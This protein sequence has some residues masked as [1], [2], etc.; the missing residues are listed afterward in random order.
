M[1][2]YLVSSFN[3]LRRKRIGR[4]EKRAFFL[5]LFSCLRRIIIV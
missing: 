3:K 1:N 4:G 2:L 5:I